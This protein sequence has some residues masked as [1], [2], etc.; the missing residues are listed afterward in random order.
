MWN[1]AHIF[2]NKKDGLH[3]PNFFSNKRH[4]LQKKLFM[5][6]KYV[7]INELCTQMTSHAIWVDEITGVMISIK[8]VNKNLNIFKNSS[9]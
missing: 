4:G 8:K 5:E 6:K 1:T 2:F 7:K 3:Y 9:F